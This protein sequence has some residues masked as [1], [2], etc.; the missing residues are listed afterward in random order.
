VDDKLFWGL[1]ALP[2]LRDY[3]AGNAWFD[4][5]AWEQARQLPAGV[6]RTR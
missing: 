5:P 2:M 3:L 1:D 4:G 6:Q